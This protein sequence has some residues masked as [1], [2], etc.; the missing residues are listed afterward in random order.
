MLVGALVLVGWWTGVHRLTTVFPGFTSMK[1]NTAVCLIAL[2]A[3][4]CLGARCPRTAAVVTAAA[5]LLAAGTAVEI[6]LGAHTRLDRL[7]PGVD[8]RGDSWQMA[9]MTALCLVALA[10]SQGAAQAGRRRSQRVAATLAL[11]ASYV[12]LIGYLYGVS[13]LYTV[14]AYSA[15]ALPT[16]IAIASLA[17]AQLVCDAGRGAWA[18]LCDNGPAGAMTRGLV[19]ALVLVPPLVGKL[20]L[21]GQD[22]GWFDTEFGVAILVVI[23]TAVTLSITFRTAAHVQRANAARVAAAAELAAVNAGLEHEVQVRTLQAG[24]SMARF[25]TAFHSSPIGQ[26]LIDH[27]GIVQRANHMLAA[28]TG[29]PV[30]HLTGRHAAEIFGPGQWA[31]D[32]LL[33]EAV[34]R[35]DEASFH[36]EREL[37]A[38]AL[39]RWVLLHGAKVDEPGG[40]PVLLLELQDVTRR[41]AAE[42]RAQ[43]LA[44]HDALTGLPNRVLLLD[45]GQQAL[46]RA[47][48]SGRGVGAL[49]VD[50]D[51]FKSINDSLGHEA[52]DAALVEVARRL[53]AVARAADT[54]ARLGGD[55]FVVLCPDVDSEADVVALA[56]ELGACL[57]RPWSYSG[58]AVSLEASV[59]VALAR[60]GD[61]A[62]TLIRRADQAMYQAK[63]SGRARFEVFDDALRAHVASRLDVELGLRGAVQRGEVE[64]WFQ[65]IVELC[66]ARPVA[67][68]ALARWRR[69]DGTL[70]QPSDFIGVAEDVGLI[71]QVGGHVLARACCAVAAQDGDL[72]VSVNVSARQF[73]HEDFQAVVERALEESGLS[74][75]RL[76]LELTESTVV[77]AVD[78]AARCFQA[79]RSRGVRLAIDDFGTGYSSFEHLRTFEVDLIKVDATFTA[80]LAS[81]AR[82]RALVGTMLSMAASLGLDVVAEGIESAAQ[83]DLLAE[84]G[85]R[86]GQGYLFSRPAPAAAI[87]AGAAALPA[88]RDGT[89]RAQGAVLPE[90]A[91]S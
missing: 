7:V 68:E 27:A 23:M 65:P 8:L 40:P 53:S 14:G 49:F 10:V 28:M 26:A 52:G 86:W 50:V 30:E 59:G 31:D 60:A 2:S 78:S 42:D 91:G 62:E 1:P 43:F 29:R 22:R 73:V 84:L 89:G 54:V 87:V 88:P 3:G 18:L 51:R 13:H 72:S 9:P 56:R 11:G 66:T 79:L 35:G 5:G 20:R 32:A 41:R 47:R 70:V 85:C 45:R 76:W 83:R 67:W 69:A 74:P 37:H 21:L 34:L 80:G 57:S 16:A 4:A 81:S 71:P 46:V 44:L 90:V 38:G 55:E 19:P 58:Q 33:R 39:A 17:T 36:V 63:G 15:V 24:R 64:T 82:D 77:Q 75:E 6:A 25:E 61:D 48:R 12:A